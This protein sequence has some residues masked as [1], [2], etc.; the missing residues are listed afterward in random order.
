VKPYLIKY[1]DDNN[2]DTEITYM[3][4]DYS[5]FKGKI[6]QTFAITN[7]Q[8]A[9]MTEWDDKALIRMYRQGLK[10]NVKLELMR[11]GA[12]MDT[13]DEL[14]NESIRVDSNL[15]KLSLELYPE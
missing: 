13:L 14:I 10:N 11:S 5:V 8:Y 15:Y 2:D 7:E 1:M 6:R 3:F 4:E 12:T 9:V